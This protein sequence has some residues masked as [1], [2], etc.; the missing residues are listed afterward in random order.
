MAAGTFLE[1]RSQVGMDHKALSANAE[2]WAASIQRRK[3]SVPRAALILTAASLLCLLLSNF[4]GVSWRNLLTDIDRI[5][6]AK[7]NESAFDWNDIKPATDLQ[8]HAC[9]GNLQCARL[10]VPMDYNAAEDSSARVALA[11]VRRPAKV[12]V[13][14]PSYG[15][16]ILI[17]PGGPGGSGVAQMLYH[18]SQLRTIVDSDTPVDEASESDKFFDIIGFDPR[19]INH[20]RPLLT[21]FPD[22]FARSTWALQAGAEGLL[23]SSETSLRTAW[24]RATALSTGCS[25]RLN[26]DDNGTNF[27]EH[28][29]TTPAAADMVSIIEAHGQWREKEGQKAQAV[30]DCTQGHEIAQRTK[31]QKG[32]EKL[33][34]WGFSYGTVIGST[35]AAIYPERVSRIVLDG[36]VDAQDYFNGPWLTN[37]EDSDQILHKI[38][39]YC[40]DAGPESCPIWRPGGPDAILAALDKLLQDIWDDPLAVV[41]D[42]SHGPEI[43]TWTDVKMVLKDALYQ[44]MHLGPIMAKLV[45]DLTN[46]TGRVFADAKQAARHPACRSA[47]CEAAGP[48]SDAC[49]LPDWNE[50]EATSAILC[51][52]A[53]GIGSL[54]EDEFREYWTTLRNQSSTMAD[55]WAQIRLGCAGWQ[56][57]AKW[58]Y[59]NPKNDTLTMTTE[60]GH[61]ILWVS[62]TLDTVTPLANAQ[63]MSARFAGSVVLQQDCE[64]HCSFAAPS[65]CTAKSVRRYF[66]TGVLPEQGTLCQA[67]EKPFQP[68]VAQAQREGMSEMDAELLEALTEM[69][70]VHVPVPHV[71]GMSR[72][73]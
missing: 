72:I 21:C 22:T 47:S 26:N 50:L 32:K 52:D 33:Q 27:L 60:T 73:L 66:Q 63:R 18:G 54:T 68:A 20:S 8:Y 14:S 61:P 62:N 43:I 48:F 59:T 16:A 29:N 53:E 70:R 69:T 34:Y 57:R 51:T 44:P 64:G 13:S 38:T 39:E 30:A 9:Y 35:F 23:G 37:L 67:D 12:P 58:R 15:G 49:V 1:V 6:H 71:L 2:P 31:W 3:T 28:V 5:S 41:G 7:A 40:S 36:V 56:A 17:N 11:I 4:S 19:G 42:K 45:A 10:D 46:G 24:R 55:Y 25:S 65:V